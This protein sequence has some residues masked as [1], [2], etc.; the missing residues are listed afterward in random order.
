MRAGRHAVPLLAGAL[1]L[2]LAGCDPA[3]G[4][5]GAPSSSPTTG[6]PTEA[7]EPATPG[8]GRPTLEVAPAD[9][10]LRVKAQGL[11]G[12]RVVEVLPCAAEHVRVDAGAADAM[13]SFNSDT[14]V[15]VETSDDGS[16]RTTV[17]PE[18]FLKINGHEV[19]CD[20]GCVLGVVTDGRTVRATA[21]FELPDGVVVPDA[22]RLT[23][24][25]W[26]YDVRRNTGNAV[27]TGTGFEPGADVDLS[28]CPAA[29]DGTGVDGPDCLYEYGTAA[30]ADSRGAFRVDVAA[31]PL[32]QRSDG[33]RADEYVDCAR[34]PAV[35]AIGAPWVVG[36]RIAVATFDT[37]TRVRTPSP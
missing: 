8:A 36:E 35:C 17:D 9:G 32:F 37:A 3:G 24:E 16:L 11:P 30:V 34:R 2:A 28:Q 18:V 33:G 7:A 21:P 15:A 14:G 6:S 23:I 25:S 27:V 4:S 29:A 22:P 12:G 5:A 13:C 1:L 31:Y 19:L 26:T 20:T 10:S